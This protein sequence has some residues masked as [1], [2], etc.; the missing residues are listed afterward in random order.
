MMPYILDSCPSCC[1][2]RIYIYNL[3]ITQKNIVDYI[4][5][6]ERLCIAG[7]SH[8]RLYNVLEFTMQYTL[9]P[10]C[11][12]IY[13]LVDP[14]FWFII[15]GCMNTRGSAQKANIYIRAHICNEIH[16]HAEFLIAIFSDNR[17]SRHIIFWIDPHTRPY[18]Y[19]L[20]RGRI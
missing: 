18:I 9:M 4:T 20:K 13:T 11:T 16:F 6:P 12:Y 14:P 7:D 2:L 19:I 10:S 5:R 15:H 3:C 17:F 1:V 8:K